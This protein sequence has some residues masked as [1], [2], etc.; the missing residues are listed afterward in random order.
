MSD[1]LSFDE[2]VLLHICGQIPLWRWDHCTL[3]A[4]WRLQ[5]S[6]HPG[7]VWMARGLLVALLG[8][9]MALFA[10]GY[11]VGQRFL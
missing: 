7:V 1:E 5:D 3:L 11:G 8:N 9:I 6:D 2:Q 4:L 10:I